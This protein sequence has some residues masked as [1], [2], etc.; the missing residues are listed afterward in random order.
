MLYKVVVYV[1]QVQP[2]KEIG[3][4]LRRT[5]YYSSVDTTKSTSTTVLGR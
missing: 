3:D 2:R 4:I 5:E 1:L